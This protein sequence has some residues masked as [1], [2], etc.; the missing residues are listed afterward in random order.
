MINFFGRGRYYIARAIRIEC[1]V[2][3]RTA[4]PKEFIVIKKDRRDMKETP[5][6]YVQRILAKTKGQN[7]LKVQAATAR[8]LERLVKSIPI[9]K[10]RRRPAADKWSVAEILAH[11]GDTE[12]AIGWRLR[13]ILA[14]PGTPLQAF[15]QDAWLATGHYEKRDPRQCIE[16]FRAAREANLV[17]LK[18]LT[19]EQWKQYGLH[20]ERG[21]ETIERIVQLICGHD[22][23]HIEQIAAILATNSTRKPGKPKKTKRK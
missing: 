19:K 1:G 17:V 16:Q 22:I 4:S 13:S 3:V 18:S 2:R 10:L 20:S 6:E 11:L 5:Q 7:P 14:A 8:E 12:I 15:D 9:S 21:E 23:N